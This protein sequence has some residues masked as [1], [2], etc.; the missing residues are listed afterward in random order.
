MWPATGF[1]KTNVAHEPK[2]L[3]TTGLRDHLLQ[4]KNK[5]LLQLVKCTT[6]RP[7]WSFH[8]I[9]DI[10]VKDQRQHQKPIDIWNLFASTVKVTVSFWLHIER[11]SQNLVDYNNSFKKINPGTSS[12]DIV[13][14]KILLFFNFRWWCSPNEVAWHWLGAKEGDCVMVT[15]NWHEILIWCFRLK[16]TNR[17]HF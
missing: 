12:S 17:P 1:W 8:S 15:S 13:S 11:F 14:G 5:K 7:A 3:S 2:S 10:E 9:S 16:Q 6:R 4:R